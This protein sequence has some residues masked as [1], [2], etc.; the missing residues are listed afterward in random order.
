MSLYKKIPNLQVGFNMEYTL[1]NLGFVCAL[2]ANH[3]DIVK[4][5]VAGKIR[6]M[7]CGNVCVDGD[8]VPFGTAP[9]EN[10]HE[11]R[12]FDLIDAALNQIQSDIELLKNIYDIHRLGIIIGSSNTGVGEAQQH[13]N[14]SLQNNTQIDKSVLSSLDRKSVV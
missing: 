12:C 1:K 7:L 5:A 14:Q 3:D 10:K 9:V 13:I 2:G 8:K 6:A 11:L 4:N